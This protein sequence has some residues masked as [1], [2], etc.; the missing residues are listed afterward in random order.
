MY[1]QIHWSGKQCAQKLHILQLWNWEIGTMIWRFLCSCLYYGNPNMVCVTKIKYVFTI[2]HEHITV[3]FKCLQ[4]DTVTSISPFSHQLISNSNMTIKSRSLFY[5][6]MNA[7]VQMYVVLCKSTKIFFK[8]IF[9]WSQNYCM[10]RK[11]CLNY[12]RNVVIQA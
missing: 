1:I 8:N 6:W 4:F 9:W 2:I 10:K 5:A 12:T 3:S 11:Y 7:Y